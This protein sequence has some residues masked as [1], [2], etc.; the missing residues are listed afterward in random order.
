M[1]WW[2]RDGQKRRSEEDK[3]SVPSGLFQKCDACGTTLETERVQRALY[4][5]TSCGHHFVCPTEERIRITCDQGVFDERDAL[6]QPRDPLEF[7][8]SKRYA[9]RLH[10][11]QKVVGVA[12]AFRAGLARVDGHEVSIGFFVF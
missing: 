1:A 7:R 9:D 3:R 10:A 5:C 4:C 6:I 12:D 2:S 8:D 11:A